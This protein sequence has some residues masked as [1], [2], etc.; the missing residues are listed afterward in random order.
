MFR[1]SL[2]RF[3]LNSYSI[4]VALGEIM[5][6]Y[7]TSRPLLGVGWSTFSGMRFGLL[8]AKEWRMA[9]VNGKRVLDFAYFPKVFEPRFF[10]RFSLNV[11]S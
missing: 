7:A 4:E 5:T 8:Y 1:F 9:L 10:R 3:E 11:L 6:D 2:V